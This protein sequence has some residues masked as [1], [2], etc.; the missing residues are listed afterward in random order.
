MLGGVYNPD[1]LEND[2]SSF[3]D[4]ENAFPGDLGPVFNNA[5]EE[6]D[7][8]PCFRSYYQRCYRDKFTLEEV[9][10]RSVVLTKDSFGLGEA[11]P[12]YMPLACG[13]IVQGKINVDFENVLTD[14]IPGFGRPDESFA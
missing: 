1:G 9:L 13:N 10:G 14:T 3:I 12:A 6:P 11:R 4:P 5:T 7:S 2:V 8:G